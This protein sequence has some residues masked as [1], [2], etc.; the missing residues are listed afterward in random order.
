MDRLYRRLAGLAL[1]AIMV[2]VFIGLMACMPVPIGKA[3]SSRIDPAL[4]GMWVG[5]IDDSEVVLALDPWDKRTWLVTVYDLEFDDD[6]EPDF[7]SIDMTYKHAR[8]FVD[9]GYPQFNEVPIYKGWRT[10]VG[11]EWFFVWELMGMELGYDLAD[12]DEGRFWFIWRIKELAPGKIRLF[13][14]KDGYEGFEAIEGF[15]EKV[16]DKDFRRISREVERVIRRNIDD[17]KLYDGV[18]DD[19][20]AILYRLTKEDFKAM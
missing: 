17:P 19:E 14:V 20:A 10:R 5:I 18:D 11:G 9:N 1:A 16:S 15:D 4:S 12:E 13:M 3:E 6:Y 8:E 2:P 7:E